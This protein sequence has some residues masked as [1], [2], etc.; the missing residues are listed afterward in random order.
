MK[1]V[2]LSPEL[3]DTEPSTEV[4][5]ADSGIN[6]RTDLVQGILNMGFVL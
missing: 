3:A 2:N 6:L 5:L 4:R 1:D